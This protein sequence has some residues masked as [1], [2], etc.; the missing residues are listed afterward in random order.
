MG[1]NPSEKLKKQKE[2]RILAL[3]SRM[4]A[5]MFWNDASGEYKGEVD[6]KLPARKFPSKDMVHYFHPMAWVRQMKLINIDIKDIGAWPVEE[7]YKTWTRRI[8]SG[9]ENRYVKGLKTAS[10]NHKGLDINFSGGGNT[11]IGAPVYATHDGYA[12][13]VKDNTSGSGGRYIEIMSTNKKFMT[14]YLHLSKIV[15]TKKQKVLKGEKIGEL[16]ASYLGEEIHPKMSAHLHYEVRT[17]KNE[18]YDGVIDPTEGK[19][20]KKKPI[21]LLDPQDWIN[22][23][24]SFNY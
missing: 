18:A 12:S 2:S 13:F 6:T 16:G 8:D 5:L 14:R 21:H 10:R 20:Y 24:S 11:D 22:N 7:K 1:T 4:T 9:V 17:V 19:G 23:P 3:E 15:I